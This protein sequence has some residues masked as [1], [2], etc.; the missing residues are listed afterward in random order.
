YRMNHPPGTVA[1][2]FDSTSGEAYTYDFDTEK[3][4]VDG[5]DAA[6]VSRNAEDTP[7]AS[8]HANGQ[9]VPFKIDYPEKDDK[10]VFLSPPNAGSVFGVHNIGW[11]FVSAT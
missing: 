2:N 9:P 6:V 4:T 1:W 8:M 3:Q 11:M 5:K 7:K 10:G